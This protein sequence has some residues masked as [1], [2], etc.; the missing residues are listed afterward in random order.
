MRRAA[1]LAAAVLGIN[2][3]GQ[4]TCV[5]GIFHKHGCDG[6]DSG[7]HKLFHGHGWGHKL[8]HHDDCGGCGHGLFRGHGCGHKFFH[9]HL[10]SKFHG[11]GCN[12]GPP[13]VYPTPDVPPLARTPYI[14]P[15]RA[16]RDFW[17]LP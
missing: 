15:N 13:S 4:A 8:F 3:A 16:P 1:L 6:C 14:H 5:A 2:L 11:H 17:M 7:G 12:D 10:T 9:G